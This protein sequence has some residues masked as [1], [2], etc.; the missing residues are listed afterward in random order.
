MKLKIKELRLRK[1]WTQTELARQS[2]V[3][4]TLISRIEKH[5]QNIGIEVLCKLKKALNCSFDELIECDEG[6]G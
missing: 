3:D 5:N 1:G 4:R 2:G 6:D